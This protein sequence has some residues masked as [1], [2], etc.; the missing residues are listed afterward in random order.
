MKTL[1]L[2]TMTYVSTFDKHL[3]E[4]TA[5]AY[6]ARETVAD[7]LVAAAFEA[8]EE[9]HSVNGAPVAPDFIDLTLGA[10]KEMAEFMVMAG[11]D[12][13]V[14][15]DAPEDIYADMLA[16]AREYLYGCLEDVPGANPSSRRQA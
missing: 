1:K 5:T 9:T 12:G 14:R 6:S 4:T 2:A 16:E 3:G 8:L 10:A 11:Q 7:R 13:F 15:G